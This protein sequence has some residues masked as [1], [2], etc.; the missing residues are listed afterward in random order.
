MN[1]CKGKA[2]SN[3]EFT[4][5]WPDVTNTVVKK[6]VINKKKSPKLK[7]LYDFGNQK[8]RENKKGLSWATFIFPPTVHFKTATCGFLLVQ[9]DTKYHFIMSSTFLPS[10]RVA[11]HPLLPSCVGEGRHRNSCVTVCAVRYS[12]A[13]HTVQWTD[14]TY[15]GRLYVDY[16]KWALHSTTVRRSQGLRRGPR[17]GAAFLSVS[18]MPEI[19]RFPQSCLPDRRKEP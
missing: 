10:S 12:T 15:V 8:C 7:N 16:S 2:P 1:M 3:I 11:P 17:G 19:R 6:N 18:P 4:A 14:V 13:E 5:V 9:A